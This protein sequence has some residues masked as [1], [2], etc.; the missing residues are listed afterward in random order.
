MTALTTLL[1]TAVAE[2]PAVIEVNGLADVFG[3]KVVIFKLDNGSENI[4][5]SEGHQ[6]DG[7][8]L[9]DLDP[10]TATARFDNRGT[11]QAIH[12]SNAVLAPAATATVANGGQFSAEAVR[13]RL[14][15]EAG[16]LPADESAAGMAAGNLGSAGY[17]FGGGAAA[18]P[19]PNPT[20]GGSDAAGTQIGTPDV[21][22]PSSTSGLGSKQ[23]EAWKKSWQYRDAQNVE[24][25]RARDAAAIMAGIAEPYPLTPLTPP[26]T[27]AQLVSADT[28]YFPNKDNFKYR[29][30]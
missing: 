19:A 22:S 28:L 5:L 14:N 16:S 3:N 24:A 23:D 11:I 1:A 7:V 15:N 8:R 25:A 9:L 30:R 17:A 2:T 13:A 26:G 27:P 4:L 29:T 20:T 10:A 6:R 12:I 21:G 18:A